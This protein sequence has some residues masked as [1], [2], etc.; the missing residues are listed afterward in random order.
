M[1][2]AETA[3]L[4]A[5]I[6][7]IAPSDALHDA[8]ERLERRYTLAVVGEFSSG[9]SFLLNALLGKVS[10]DG[11]RLGGLLAV[12]IN[13]STATITE[14]EYGAEPSAMARYPSGR[15][16]RIPLDRLAR[17]V[18]VGK[19]DRGGLHDATAD[20]DSAP[21]FVSVRTDS[22]FLESGFIVADTPG[23]AS[24]NPSHRRATLSYLPRSDAILYLI[25]TQQPFSEGDA[26]FLGLIGEHVRTIFIV[27]TKIDLWRAPEA[28]GLA[29][30]ENARARIVDRA[31]RFAPHAEVYAVSAREY[32][33]AML[34]GDEAL[35]EASGFPEFLAALD[36]SL[37]E[38]VERARIRR[39]LDA[40][41]G[42]LDIATA[43]NDRERSLLDRSVPELREMRGAA[44]AELEHRERALARERD[45]VERAGRE[46]RERIVAAGE[47]LAS[48]TVRAVAAAVDVADIARVRD[49]NRLH[50]LV[51]GAVSPLLG[52][53]GSEA[54]AQI[55]RALERT[56]RD[57][58]TLRV[59]DIAA[60]ELGGEP[61]TGAWSRDLAAGIRSAIVLGGIGGPTVSFVHAIGREF[62]SHGVGAYMKRELGADLR[63]RFF[64]ALSSDLVAFV[65]DIA[66][67]VER[68]Y[69]RVAGEI[70]TERRRA[71]DERIGPIDRAIAAAEA[72]EAGVAAARADDERTELTSA[73]AELGHL[74]ADVSPA[75]TSRDEADAGA[76]VVH[77]A[78]DP[79]VYELG[80]NPQRYRVVLLGALRRGKSSLI[81]AIA[82]TTIMDDDAAHEAL[83]PVHVRYG[84]A[85][86]AYVLGP[87]GEWDAIDVAHAIRSAT[88]APVLIETPWSLPRELVLVHAPA[89]DSGNDRA[90]EIAL[91]AVQS[92]SEIVGLFSRQLS[93]RELDIFARAGEF[94][95][96]LA[97]AHTIADNEQPAERRTVVELAARYVRERDLAVERIFTISAHEFLTAKAAGRAPAGWNELGAL[98]ETLSAHAEEHMQRLAARTRASS[99]ARE[100]ADKR[101]AAVSSRPNLR[102]AISRLLGRAHED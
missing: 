49:R 38:R 71:R 7:R 57:R 20:D 34:D 39:T 93:D 33:L 85:E 29:V 69:E 86:R 43:R 63:E 27:Q 87:G 41:S 19:D 90:E 28:N 100:T 74:L 67:R 37:V 55:A 5:R 62:S 11:E 56:A 68:I 94:G 92:A 73:R 59:V 76:T 102:R 89:F 88:T 101:D 50:V 83:F 77:A 82:G 60:V 79:V 24:L 46:R 65:D 22:P 81:N 12:D 54:A 48:D 75:P 13:P 97:L 66:R 70:D 6:E 4:A 10:R 52:E 98:R 15:E 47:A 80:L 84:T 40:A 30:W 96:P 3:A 18:A 64:P 51:D 32:A 8:R 31:R 72:G 26:A 61:E 58:R 45:D 42:A 78:F 2:R 1:S 14:L 53:F 9:K 17:F 23:L 16:E 25:D 91:A 36:R 99:D 35:R 21:Q 44:L 95:K